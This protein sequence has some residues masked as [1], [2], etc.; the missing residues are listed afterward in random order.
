MRLNERTNIAAGIFENNINSNE[1]NIFPNPSNGNF[2]LAYTLTNSEKVSISVYDFTGKKIDVKSV[3][4]NSG[5][6]TLLV[7][8]N[9]YAKGIYLVEIIAG[10]KK[11]TKK[12]II[13]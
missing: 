9:D 1:L 3:N 2:T 13:Q 8:G 6:N 4:G 5:L 7:S 12:L 10:D 11:E